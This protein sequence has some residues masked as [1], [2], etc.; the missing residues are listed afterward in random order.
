M[1]TAHLLDRPGLLPEARRTVEDYEKEHDTRFSHL[2]HFAP[3]TLETLHAP[4]PLPP[5][6]RVASD[7]LPEVVERMAT[8][9][10]VAN[11]PAQSDADR[12][13]YLRALLDIY[14]L[15]P[16]RVR[17]RVTAP[18]TAVVAPERE[19][20]ILAERLGVLPQ[21]RSWTPQAKRIPLEGGLLVGVDERLPSPADRLVIVDGVVASGVTLMAMMRLTV[22]PG[23]AV[24][25]FTCHSTR[26]GALALARYAEQLQVSL[27]LHV[28]HVSGELNGKF[29]AVAPDAPGQLLLGDVGDT[30]SPVATVPPPRGTAP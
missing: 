25:I 21:Q 10:E 13:R 7:T 11:L 28:G 15:L 24:E 1:N 30:I 27:T 5:N 26:Q 12:A 17:D 23:A 14:G 6:V 4:G 8:V 16:V 2:V 29:Y 19:G 22:R 3:G 20:R 9:T 18:G